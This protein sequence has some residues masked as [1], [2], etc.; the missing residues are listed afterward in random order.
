MLVFLWELQNCFDGLLTTLNTDKGLGSTDTL[1]RSHA[2]VYFYLM[3]IGTIETLSAIWANILYCARISYPGPVQTTAQHEPFLNLTPEMLN[4]FWAFLPLFFTFIYIDT[5][6]ND[7]K[8]KYF[9]WRT[10]SHFL[11]VQCPD[12]S[13]SIGETMI[14]NKM[15]VFVSVT[16]YSAVSSLSISCRHSNDIPPLL[17][18]DKNKR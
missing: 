15:C 3:I 8:E 6:E 10:R 18:R 11:Q 17:N 4:F 2:S 12:V 7:L 14:Y 1:A 9:M 13:S 5:S 16:R